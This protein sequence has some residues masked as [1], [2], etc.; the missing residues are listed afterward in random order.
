[1]LRDFDLECLSARP[2]KTDAPLIID[3]HTVLAFAVA[4][5]SLKAIPRN[6]AQ[7]LK[8]YR[9]IQ[10]GQLSYCDTLEGL[11]CTDP[12]AFPKG[13]CV[14][15]GDRSEHSSI[16]RVLCYPYD[17]QQSNPTHDFRFLGNADNARGR[18]AMPTGPVLLSLV[19]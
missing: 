12:R 5:Q 1:M 9:S 7:R 19:R 11:E 3:P 6:F 18:W 2:I 15:V 14:F 16:E 13:F 10:L 8:I 4:L 17:T